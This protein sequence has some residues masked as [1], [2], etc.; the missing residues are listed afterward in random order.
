[1]ASAAL[2]IPSLPDEGSVID[3]PDGA[4]ARRV[5]RALEVRDD[6]GAL[7]IRY[8]DGRAEIHAPSGDVTVAAERDLVLRGERVRIEADEKLDVSAPEGDIAVSRVRF[9]AEHLATAVAA[10]AHRVEHYELEAERVVERARD[11]F[12]DVRG[13]FE[14]RIGRS[15]TVV[16]ESRT[17]HAERNA[18]VS[19]RETTIDGERILIG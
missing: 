10:A 4:S 19:E 12:R 1:M 16:R 6:G 15:R 9:V 11:A 17:V 8:V 14:A 7:L 5:G 18:I 2:E 13:L 3:L